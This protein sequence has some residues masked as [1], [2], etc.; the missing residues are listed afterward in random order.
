MKRWRVL[1]LGLIHENHSRYAPARRH[2]ITH[3][4]LHHQG[5]PFTPGTDPRHYLRN[6]Q[7]WSRNTVCPG[8]H[9]Y[10]YVQSGY[11]KDPVA[12][13]LNTR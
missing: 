13:R 1:Q 7:T 9:L 8:A 10:R 5:E 6:L 3:I 4:T 12:P 11:F 2:A